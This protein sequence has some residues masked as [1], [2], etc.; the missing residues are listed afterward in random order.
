[1]SD[2]RIAIVIL[3]GLGMGA[4]FMPWTK[5]PVMGY[6]MGTS[7]SGWITFALFLLALVIAFLGNRNQLLQGLKLYTLLVIC[8]LAAGIGVYEIIDLEGAFVS[9]EYGLYLAALVGFVIPVAVFIMGK[10]REN[11]GAGSGNEY[12]YDTEVGKKGAP[13]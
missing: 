8:F 3:A 6:T 13:D 4:T 2:Q 12:T 1:M 10:R 9:V 7:H 11:S 5:I